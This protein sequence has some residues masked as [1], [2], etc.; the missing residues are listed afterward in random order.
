M[1]WR[2]DDMLP[3]ITFTKDAGV[4]GFG[5]V[6]MTLKDFVFD[7]TMR[8]GT[9]HPELVPR[10]YASHAQDF[11]LMEFWQQD[12][13]GALREGPTLAMYEIREVKY[14]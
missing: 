3:I 13:K 5:T 14:L 4:D 11:L 9:V 10:R 2:D 7:V 1:I 12:A 6:L 8:D